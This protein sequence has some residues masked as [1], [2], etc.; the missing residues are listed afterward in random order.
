MYITFPLF[1][2]VNGRKLRQKCQIQ[3]ENYRIHLNML[4]IY[5]FCVK[6]FNAPAVRQSVLIIYKLGVKVSISDL[7][8]QMS[9]YM[10]DIQ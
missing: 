7:S 1:H 9:I 2:C 8:R 6:A 4:I 3:Q 10:Y 5:K